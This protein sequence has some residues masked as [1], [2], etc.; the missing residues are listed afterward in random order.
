VQRELQ[1]QLSLTYSKASSNKLTDRNITDLILQLTQDGMLLP[2]LFILTNHIPSVYTISTMILTLKF[3]N[4][5]FFQSLFYF[6]PFWSLSGDIEL[7]FTVDGLEYVT[8]RQLWKEIEREV[9][10]QGGRRS[11]YGINNILSVDSS[12]VDRLILNNAISFNSSSSLIS[13]SQIISSSSSYSGKLT[14]FENSSNLFFSNSLFY[15]IDTNEL[16]NG[17][18]N[19]KTIR[20]LSEQLRLQGIA[21]LSEFASRQSLPYPYVESIVTHAINTLIL[22]DIELDKEH[23]TLVTKET[24][25]IFLKILKSVLCA[26]TRPIS[27]QKLLLQHP[28]VYS[29]PSL[30]NDGIEVLSREE[31]GSF[32]TKSRENIIFYPQI[33]INARQLWIENALAKDFIISNKVLE[34]LGITSPKETD[35]APTRIEILP[36]SVISHLLL[37]HIDIAINEASQENNIL[38]FSPPLLPDQMESGDIKYLIQLIN[39]DTNTNLDVSQSIATTTSST[40]SKDPVEK[41]EGG[42][43]LSN[44]IIA[45]GRLLNDIYFVP[46]GLINRCINLFQ[47]YFEEQKRLKCEKALENSTASQIISTSSSSSP[48]PSSL[49]SSTII[50][51]S[52]VVEMIKKWC[53]GQR[54]HDLALNKLAQILFPQI[55]SLSS[56]TSTS[57]STSSPSSWKKDLWLEEFQPILLNVVFFMHSVESLPTAVSP[58]QRIQLL[59][60]VLSTLGKDL[61]KKL[62][63]ACA[64]K[65]LV[66][67]SGELEMEET[68]KLLPNEVAKPLKQVFVLTSGGEKHCSLKRLAK[69]VDEVM[70]EIGCE[71]I[72]MDEKLKETILS[73]H[74]G[75]ALN[76][77]NSTVEPSTRLRLCLSLIYAKISGHM[78]LITTKHLNLL[79]LIITNILQS[80]PNLANMFNIDMTTSIANAY[81]SLLNTIRAKQSKEPEAIQEAL[82][83]FN[84]HME[85]LMKCMI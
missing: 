53:P 26:C 68:L 42:G 76:Q 50:S 54:K 75:S 44:A 33:F 79:Q 57:S 25:T 27:V 6:S 39:F 11:I 30:L 78:L 36:S 8:P 85:P 66:W 59:Q 20:I 81:S 80:S 13:S 63:Q 32:Q 37:E 3:L 24:R 31:I 16:I 34:K 35:F 56:Q 58:D 29:T 69:N 19:T 40:Q 21:N 23:R 77:L 71:V 41:Q 12:H 61:S 5:H 46:N 52:F 70:V 48:I 55:L 14:S 73:T 64:A 62:S 2:L 28:D 15:L 60:H 67:Q 84:N 17:S 43:K 7:I 38:A 51:H 10:E 82:T 4:S 1:K 83:Q 47:Q 72:R 65:F 22:S 9:E 74:R 49:E 45:H 18:Y